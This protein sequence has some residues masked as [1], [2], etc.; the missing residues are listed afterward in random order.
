MFDFLKRKS[1]IIDVKVDGDKGIIQKKNKWLIGAIV[2]AV[3]FLA[4]GS[5]GGDKKEKPQQTNGEIGVEP[6]SEY[7]RE[8]EE[9]LA[10]I[11]SGIKGAG[12]VKVMMNFDVRG[13]KV[14]AKNKTDS[15]ETQV[16]EQGS[17]SRSSGEESIL[18]YGS[19]GGEQPYVVKE[20]L[21]VPS[22]V[23]VIATGASDEK[24]RLE[25]YEAV[26]ALYGMS[27]HRIKITASSM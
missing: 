22:G 15:L 7:I 8:T 4:F 6:D 11:L 17:E 1:K 19:G 12:N 9:R 16:T 14:L 26:K 23:L 27:G 21:P 25:I 20:R 10:E 2:I 3:C 13:E 18:L 24:V 5:F